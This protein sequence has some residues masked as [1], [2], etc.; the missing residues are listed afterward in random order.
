MGLGQ[1]IF[2][3]HFSDEGIMAT[4]YVGPVPLVLLILF[5][6]YFAIRNKIKI[7]TFINLEKSNFYD[8]D[9]NFRKGNLVPL[10]GNAYAN[11]AHVFLFTYAFKYAKM[12]GLNQGVIPIVTTFATIFNSV[13]FYFYFGEKLSCP[14]ILGMALTVS[15]V[16]F[17][18]VDASK[19][20]SAE[21]TQY[22]FESKYAYYALA[23]A[24][25][26]PFHFSFKHFL[27]RKYKGTYDHNFIGVDSGI[28]E[29]TACSVFA[30]IYG[31][32]VGF[33]D[34]PKFMLGSLS[35][36]LLVLGRVFIAFAVA[37][38]QAGPA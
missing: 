14:K 2:A 17:L 11:I 37:E 22:D 18:A 13:L 19:D 5:K 32:E 29:T 23:L 24:M 25:A 4:G 10:I 38:G 3:Q 30:I 8:E 9:G 15:S 6:L 36:I 16:V 21:A 31:L 27:I 35:G 33:D 1:Y 34:F 28:L 7:G 20:N 26:V 12:G